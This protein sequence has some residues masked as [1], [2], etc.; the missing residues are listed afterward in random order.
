MP[1]VCPVCRLRPVARAVGRGVCEDCRR[2]LE[3]LLVPG[4][5]CPECGGVLDGVMR[6]CSECMQVG[7]RPWEQAV[8][9]FLYRGIVRLLIQRFKYQG[10][11]ALVPVFGG[12]MARAWLRD[13]AIAPDVIVP[14]PLHWRREA[15]RGFNQAELTARVV[16]RILG[17]PLVK[18]LRRVRSTPKQAYLDAVERR[19]NMRGA[20]RAVSHRRS[21][22]QDR[23]VLVVDDV[24]TTGAT[25][26]AAA[27]ALLE[28]GAARVVVLTA[29]R[30]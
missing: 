22:V 15:A 16:G 6:A 8:A 27:R 14:T 23:T 17:I 10:D 29:A 26:E 19:R 7:P 12:Y 30:G 5:R 21:A 3:G 18:A 9:A 25:L 11:T 1:A 4:P 13:G 2:D 28:A 24:L 20:F